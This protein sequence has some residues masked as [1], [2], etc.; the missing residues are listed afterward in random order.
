MELRDLDRLQRAEKLIEGVRDNLIV[1]GS[2]PLMELQS[3]IALVLENALQTAMNLLGE[4]MENV[5]K[6]LYQKQ[7]TDSKTK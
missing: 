2:S 4:V 5:E 6:E 3:N 1:L 7:Q